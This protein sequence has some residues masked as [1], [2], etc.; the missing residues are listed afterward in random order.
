[1]A[2]ALV[3]RVQDKATG[4]TQERVEPLQIAVF[5]G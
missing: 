4:Q 1:V 2:A 3:L 5:A